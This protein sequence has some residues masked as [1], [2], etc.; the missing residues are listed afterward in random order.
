MAQN[1]YI[2]RVKP[3]FQE[4]EKWLKLGMTEKD[5]AKNLSI[6]KASFIKYKKENIEFLDLIKKSRSIPVED[7]KG[8]ML[9]RALGFQYTEKTV[10]EDN[11]GYK[12]TITNTKTALPDA[13]SGLIL[14]KHWD[15]EG[16]WTTDPQSLQLKKEEFELKKKQLEQENW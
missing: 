8:A 2:T 14:L 4:I 13:T 9:K 3:R 10:I 1:K 7:I 5:I 12:K 16:G 11:D 6:S 15:K